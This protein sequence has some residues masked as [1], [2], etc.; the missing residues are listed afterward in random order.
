MSTS[1]SNEIWKVIKNFE[2]CASKR[3]CQLIVARSTLELKTEDLVRLENELHEKKLDYALNPDPNFFKAEIKPREK[4]LETLTK[5]IEGLKLKVESLENS[6]ASNED[7][8]SFRK[9]LA[10][11]EAEELAIQVPKLISE[12]NQGMQAV[13]DSATKLKYIA[14]TCRE[15]G[16]PGPLKAV[17]ENIFCTVKQIPNHFVF[18]ETTKTNYHDGAGYNLLTLTYDERNRKQVIDGLLNK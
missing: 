3:R 9:D 13:Y 15:L 6:V 1:N 8:D 14:Q 10:E 7:L 12:Y 11:A 17:D 5:E 18:I 4:G 16:F 2:T